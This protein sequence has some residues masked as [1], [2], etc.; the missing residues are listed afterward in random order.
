MTFSQVKA[1][2]ANPGESVFY[3]KAYSI[4][5]EYGRIAIVHAGNEQDALDIAAD[6]GKLDCLIMSD[7]DHAE[8]SENLWHDSYIHAGN[9]SAPYWSEYLSIKAIR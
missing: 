1:Q 5:N 4:H 6:A 9:D 7:S 3:D 2:I 8:Y